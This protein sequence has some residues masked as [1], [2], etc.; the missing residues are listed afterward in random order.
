MVAEWL[1]SNAA[2]A[3]ASALAATASHS[4]AFN[5]A[6]AATAVAVARLRRRCQQRQQVVGGQLRRQ[7]NDRV[8]H[9]HG[10]VLRQ[11]Q[12]E[13]MRRFRHFLDHVGDGGAHPYCV[14]G[15]QRGQHRQRVAAAEP[16]C[17]RSAGWAAWRPACAP[18]SSVSAR[19]RRWRAGDRRRP[20]RRCSWPPRRAPLPPGRPPATAAD[21]AANPGSPRRTRAIS[22]ACMPP[23]A[24]AG[25][26]VA[27]D[28]CAHSCALRYA[29]P[30]CSPGRRRAIGR[31]RGCAIGPSTWA[32]ADVVACRSHGQALLPMSAGGGRMPRPACPRVP[33]MPRLPSQCRGT[34]SGTSVAAAA[35]IRWPALMDPCEMGGYRRRPAGR[36]RRIDTH[37]AAAHGP[38]APVSAAPA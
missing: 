36:G 32:E 35:R 27:E 34:A 26:G 17:R 37:P 29:S 6:R 16:R 4:V 1:A 9:R 31:G 19:H 24:Y 18:A 12:D 10:A 21:R 11:P 20:V 38:P 30:V 25:G 28:G 13:I 22:S 15:D 8:A 23:F 14:V 5:P 7:T 2:M 33:S 3:A